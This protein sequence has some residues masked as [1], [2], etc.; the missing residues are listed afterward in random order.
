MVK[1][2]TPYTLNPKF[3]ALN[4]V[5]P[6]FL[7][8]TQVLAEAI[9]DCAGDDCL[10]DALGC[11]PPHTRKDTYTHT[12]THTYTHTHTHTYIHTNRHTH[13]H[14]QTN[15]PHTHTHTHVHTHVHTHTRTHTHTHSDTFADMHACTLRV[16]RRC[17]RSNQSKLLRGCL[18]I[19]SKYHSVQ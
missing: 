10:R 3:Y 13:T 11:V 4:P 7:T 5:T 18:N 19:T 17:A 6:E 1:H 15:T 14:T 12:H 16:G 8:L 9:R 2:R